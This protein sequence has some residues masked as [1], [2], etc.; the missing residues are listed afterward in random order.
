MSETIKNMDEDEFPTFIEV[1]SNGQVALNLKP[2]EIPEY[3]NNSTEHWVFA[4]VMDSKFGIVSLETYELEKMNPLDI[5]SSELQTLAFIHK[6]INYI[7]NKWFY[8]SEDIFTQS[9]N[10][11]E[12]SEISILPE[13]KKE[14][15][16]IN[17][18]SNS[19]EQQFRFS[20][21]GINYLM[22]GFVRNQIKDSNYDEKVLLDIE[23]AIDNFLNA[24]IDNELVWLAESYVYIKR[25]ETEKALNALTKLEE[26]DVF[27]ENEKKLISEAIQEIKNRNPDNA[28]NFITD[29]FLIFKLS[30]NYSKSYLNE[31]EWTQL[32]EKTETGK[33]LLL[34]LRKLKE[35]YE[36]AKKYF[37]FDSLKEKG[38]LIFKDLTNHEDET[39]EN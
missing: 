30:M 12:N 28:L 14:I 4:M 33:K 2:I 22:R 36:K 34:K 32:L 16:K 11:L 21:L 10:N 18:T 13:V 8:L 9:I 38:K 19:E 7:N 39:T 29:N 5:P 26:S 27:S 3:W 15:K 23:G 31:V 17:F 37:N 1:T 6:G 20:A 25:G 35:S 24:G